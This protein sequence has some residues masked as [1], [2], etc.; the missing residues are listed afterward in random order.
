VR[1]EA[2][3]RRVALVDR[4]A[5]PPAP[6]P[7]AHPHHHQQATTTTTQRPFPPKSPTQP[8]ARDDFCTD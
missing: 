6:D 3:R 8:P 4:R 1:V 7:V 2:L 5:A